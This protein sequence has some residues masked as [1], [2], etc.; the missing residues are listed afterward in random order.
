[1]SCG[2]HCKMCG[3]D[4]DSM[5]PKFCE[6][7]R[8]KLIAKHQCPDCGSKMRPELPPLVTDKTTGESK[9]GPIPY[10]CMHCLAHG[11]MVLGR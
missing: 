1:M 11:R 10:V 3:K 4:K 5:L 8:E 9:F 6:S 2:Y 7:C